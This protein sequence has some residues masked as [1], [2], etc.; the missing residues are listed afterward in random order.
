MA[1]KGSSLRSLAMWAR[2]TE[3]P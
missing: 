1:M 3:A 2:A